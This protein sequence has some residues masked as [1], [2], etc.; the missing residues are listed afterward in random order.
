MLKQWDLE[1]EPP[2]EVSQFGLK[3]E[4]EELHYELKLS[5]RVKDNNV[6]PGARGTPDAGPFTFLIVSET[7]LYDL[8]LLKKSELRRLLKE[9]VDK[10][11]DRRVN[12]ESEAEALKRPRPDV[13]ATLN[14]LDQSV[15][16]VREAGDI[17]RGVL[18][19]CE[20]ILEEMEINNF[21]EKRQTDE[22]EK[23]IYPL[24][25]LSIARLTNPLDR[26]DFLDEQLSNKMSERPGAE[27]LKTHDLLVGLR[28]RLQGAI[29]KVG[30][31]EGDLWDKEIGQSLPEFRQRTEHVSAR[32]G[33]L[34]K[35]LTAVLN[36]MKDLEDDRALVQSLRQIVDSHRE[37]SP[38]L[39]RIRADREAEVWDLLNPKD[40]KDKKDKK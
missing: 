27:V 16:N 1:S 7:E 34:V 25:M 19:N 11:E 15:A 39:A 13:V 32:V 29:K 26:S 33:D 40:K 4:K 17:A 8:M 37:T 22:K 21:T 28:D 20:A 3:V 18:A 9:A 5:I 14:R 36:A 30:K 23:I 38:R 35:K 6:E 2:F 31:D 10:L 24:R 12:L